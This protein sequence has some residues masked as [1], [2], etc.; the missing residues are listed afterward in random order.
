MKQQ[1]KAANANVKT[2]PFK[3]DGP[4]LRKPAIT[5]SRWK[6]VSEVSDSATGSVRSAVALASASPSFPEGVRLEN[7]FMFFVV[8]VWSRQRLCGPLQ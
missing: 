6:E 2:K 4:T 8:I 5:T 1:N 3:V 7:K